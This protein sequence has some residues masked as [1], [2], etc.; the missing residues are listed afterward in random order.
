MKDFTTDIPSWAKGVGVVAA[1]GGAYLL[2]RMFIMF[3]FMC[4]FYFLLIT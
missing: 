4:F 1:I 2:Y 3:K